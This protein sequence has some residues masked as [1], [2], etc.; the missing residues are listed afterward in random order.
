MQMYEVLMNT[1]RTFFGSGLWR[2]ALKIAVPMVVLALIAWSNAGFRAW[3]RR[4][5]EAG[6]WQS[7]AVGIPA[8]LVKL[9]MVLVIVRLIIVAMVMQAQRFEFKHG[10]VTEANRSAVLMK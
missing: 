7:L 2:Y 5:K 3:F 6:T 4:I 8:G 9:L 10:N 1:V